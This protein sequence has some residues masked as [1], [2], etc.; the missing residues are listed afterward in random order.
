[1]REVNQPN[2]LP[3]RHHG[4]EP[5]CGGSDREEESSDPGCWLL[6]SSAVA[7]RTQPARE[8]GEFQMICRKW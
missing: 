3:V 2:D 8:S 5:M 7:A 1:M 4:R 6:E